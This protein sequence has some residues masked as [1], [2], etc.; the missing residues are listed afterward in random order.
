MHFKILIGSAIIIDSVV[1][2]VMRKIGENE[3]ETKLKFKIEFK[4]TENK[5]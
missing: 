3:F 1:T 2:Y 5:I 4:L